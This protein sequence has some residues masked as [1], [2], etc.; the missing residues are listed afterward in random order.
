MV[1]FATDDGDDE[2]DAE[3]NQPKWLK[4][5]WTST[6]LEEDAWWA[7]AEIGI[8]YLVYYGKLAS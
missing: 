4:F 8:N 2:E 5:L 3:T 6:C 7:A 1:D